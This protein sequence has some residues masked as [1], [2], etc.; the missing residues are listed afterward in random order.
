MKRTTIRTTHSTI[1]GTIALAGTG[2][3][4]AGLALAATAL[5]TDA[6]AS[7]GPRTGNGS[8]VG[9]VQIGD[10]M[11]PMDFSDALA[12]P[13]VTSRMGPQQHAALSAC[14]G[15]QQLASL[16][17]T[18]GRVLAGSYHGRTH[19]HRVQADERIGDHATFADYR[20]I[21][22]DLRGCQ[23]E[24]ASHWH[25][26]ALHRDDTTHSRAVW[27]TAYDGGGHRDGGVVA[28]WSNHH[29]AVVEVTGDPAA[30]LAMVAV[31]VSKR[32]R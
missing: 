24:P 27:M 16:L 23:R 7:A 8:S 29:L 30:D 32:L 3:L 28:A 19:G 12:V 18:G 21:V 22:D 26:G 2:V 6:F 9:T 25:Y 11:S 17:G 4:A 5:T 20:G 13:T 31:E 14:T 15:E 10:L 1:R